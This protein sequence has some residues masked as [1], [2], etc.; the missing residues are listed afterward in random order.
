MSDWS[1]D[2]FDWLRF[3]R[4]SG[5]APSACFLAQQLDDYAGPGGT[6]FPSVDRLADDLRISARQV[7]RGVKALKESGLIVTIRTG[8]GR[9][10]PSTYRLCFPDA[11]RLE[12]EQRKAARAPS[13]DSRKSA[14]FVTISP[15]ERVTRASPFE[16]VKG[17]ISSSKR[18]TPVSLSVLTKPITK[19][20][21]RKIACFSFEIVNL[22]SQ[23]RSWR[24][25]F[26]RASEMPGPEI[27]AR[28]PTVRGPGDALMLPAS[29]PPR[30]DDESDLARARAFF[31]AHGVPIKSEIPTAEVRR[32]GDSE[33]LGAG[34]APSA[35][36]ALVTLAAPCREGDAERSLAPWCDRQFGAPRM[37]RRAN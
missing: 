25:W 34:G 15:P 18:V 13:I 24:A 27:E 19:T 9:G 11:A 5:L 6:C 36:V 22:A 37:Q 20:R 23:L 29:H 21:A 28:L 2:R 17:D 33:A 30:N 7:K 1:R 10:N 32:L 8:C 35:P 12:L 31:E 26:G 16:A 3:V 14:N 4:I